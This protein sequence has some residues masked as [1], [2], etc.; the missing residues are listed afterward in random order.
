M[1][2]GIVTFLALSASLLT[3]AEFP[4]PYNSEK[5]KT[6]N[7]PSPEE[8]AASFKL[9]EGFQVTV[10]A[11][12]PEVQNPIAMA[13]DHKGRMW[14]AEN[15]TYAERGKRFDLELRDRIIILHDEDHD[16]KSDTRKVFTDKLQ[17][18]TSVELGRGGIWAMC[19]GA[20]WW[21]CQDPE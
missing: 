15:Y 21:G 11:A 20:G 14:V 10:F 5:D 8:A 9:P 4:T 1:T 3:A 19:P 6:A 12:E 13:W 18:L 2:S 7:P 17:M 16:G